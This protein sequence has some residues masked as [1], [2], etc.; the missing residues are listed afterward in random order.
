MVQT[1]NGEIIYGTT[2][3]PYDVRFSER[4]TLLR[5]TRIRNVGLETLER[6]IRDVYDLIQLKEFNNTA[7]LPPIRYNK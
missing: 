5:V 7:T 4:K 2:A 1:M 6:Q 3:I